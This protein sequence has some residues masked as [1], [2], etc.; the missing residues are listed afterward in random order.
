MSLDL[1]GLS[2]PVSNL[3]DLIAYVKGAERPP[4]REH[5]FGHGKG[6]AVA[7]FTQ[8][9]FLAGAALV[10]AFQSIQRLIFPESLAAQIKQ[11]HDRIEA[12]RASLEAMGIKILVWG[13][14]L[15]EYDVL[16]VIEAPDDTTAANL[17]L[18][19][20]L[21]VG[22]V[23]GP[24]V[25]RLNASSL[26]HTVVKTYNNLSLSYNQAPGRLLRGGPK[27]PPCP[28]AHHDL[29][30]PTVIPAADDFANP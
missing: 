23:F 4:D 19:G 22:V 15:G 28:A 24:D 29:S 10:L 14:P 12:A 21:T 1:G 13:Y 3:G 5:R 27:R 16:I 25:A 8:A 17:L 6:E 26:E 20:A 11:P 7:G 18:T 2:A 9:T 30:I